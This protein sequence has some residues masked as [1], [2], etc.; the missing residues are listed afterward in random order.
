[1]TDFRVLYNRGSLRLRL[2]ATRVEQALTRAVAIAR[3]AGVWRVQIEDQNGTPVV[4][5]S[6]EHGRA[7]RRGGLSMMPRHQAALLTS[8]L[9]ECDLRKPP[10]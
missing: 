7:T 6:G 2:P 1:M 8:C 4:A 9:A 10:E 3:E 5:T